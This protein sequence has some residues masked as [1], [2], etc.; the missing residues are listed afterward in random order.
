MAYHPASGDDDA[1]SIP[2]SDCYFNDIDAR[3]FI[4]SGATKSKIPGE[5]GGRARGEAGPRRKEQSTG[6]AASRR[7]CVGLLA[8]TP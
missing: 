7:Y 8:L 2:E 1:P 5:R 3:S 6:L 4:L